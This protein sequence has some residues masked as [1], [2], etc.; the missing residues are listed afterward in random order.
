MAGVAKVRSP[1]PAHSQ[2]QDGLH[3]ATQRRRSEPETYDAQPVHAVGLAGPGR[4][5][6]EILNSACDRLVMAG[7]LAQN[8]L[9]PAPARRPWLGVQRRGARHFV[10]NAV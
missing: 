5:R 8:P 10:A 6:G 2:D 7:R 3:I 1:A 9:L 4:L